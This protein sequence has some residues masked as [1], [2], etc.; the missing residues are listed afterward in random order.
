MFEMPSV[1]MSPRKAITLP[2]GP[3]LNSG[4][5]F[6]GNSP[7]CHHRSESCSLQGLKIFQRQNSQNLALLLRAPIEV[8]IVERDENPRTK[9]SRKSWNKLCRRRSVCQTGKPVWSKR[10]DISS[11]RHSWPVLK[12]CHRLTYTT[13]QSLQILSGFFRCLTGTNLDFE[14]YRVGGLWMIPSTVAFLTRAITP[15]EKIPTHVVFTPSRNAHHGCPQTLTGI[16]PLHSDVEEARRLQAHSLR[17]ES[18]LGSSQD[19]EDREGTGL[20]LS[21]NQY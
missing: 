11:R 15:F 19:V 4:V 3:H 8:I 13:L 12:T 20:D 2:A 7:A 14:P 9:L 6:S 21:R 5:E 16:L 18:L 17:G 1:R 10:L